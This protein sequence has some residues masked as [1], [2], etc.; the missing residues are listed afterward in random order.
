M[1]ASQ[2]GGVGEAPI[3]IPMAI[4]GSLNIWIVIGAAWEGVIYLT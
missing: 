3:N 1:R 4:P 2:V